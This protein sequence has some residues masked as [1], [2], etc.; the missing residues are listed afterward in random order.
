MR[1]EDD[2]FGEAQSSLPNDGKAIPEWRNEN[3]A[4]LDVVTGLRRILSEQRQPRQSESDGKIDVAPQRETRRYRIKR[5]FDSIDRDEF[6]QSA[7][8]TIQEF[9]RES[10]AEINQIGDPLR[11]HFERMNDLAFSCTVL[12]KG[13]SREAHITVRADTELFGGE[14]SYSFSRRATN[15]ANGFVHIEA[16]EYELY[17]RLDTF[18]YSRNREKEPLT[19]EQV[20]DALWREFTSHAGIDHE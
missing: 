20:A 14:I 3:V 12:N 13:N 2:P 19:A 17:L 15:S 16:N 11:A 1:L 4:Y 7:F 9:F 6:R 18:S 10:V 8:S 5:E